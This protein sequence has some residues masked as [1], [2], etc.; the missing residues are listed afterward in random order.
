M[1]GWLQAAYC[2][3]DNNDYGY[4]STTD[5]ATVSN[6]NADDGMIASSSYSAASTSMKDINALQNIRPYNEEAMQYH[7]EDRVP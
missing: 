7:C 5:N 4:N 1:N 2:G 3:Q 6:T